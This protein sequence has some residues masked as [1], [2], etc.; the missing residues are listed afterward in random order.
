MTINFLSLEVLGS[1]ADAASTMVLGPHWRVICRGEPAAECLHRHVLV[2]RKR[3]V[4][5]RDSVVVA[6]DYVL[7]RRLAVGGV[8]EGRI[9]LQY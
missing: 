4:V 3:E 9:K 8:E 2:L 5:G 7:T 6:A 1:N